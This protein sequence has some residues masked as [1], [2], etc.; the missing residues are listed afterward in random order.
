MKCSSEMKHWPKIKPRQKGFTLLEV[1]VALAIAAVGLGAVTRALYQNIDVAD[2]LGQK[3][4]GTWVAG[5]YLS[6][7][8]IG[9]KYL[10]AGSEQD[11]VKMAQREWQIEADY[12]PTGDNEIVRIDVTVYE[13]DER[14]RPA[15][16][17]F[18][19]LSQPPNP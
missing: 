10:S 12:T 11:S 16:R 13:G 4:I 6:E 2:R 3:M 7:Q 19:F 5:N 14:D 8:Q 15:A 18:G 9:R 1:L 17:I